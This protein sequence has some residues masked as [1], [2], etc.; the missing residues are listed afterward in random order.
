[1]KKIYLGI[2]SLVF[3]ASVFA[4]AEQAPY[5]KNDVVTS[6]A[7]FDLYTSF[8]PSYP[9]GPSTGMAA[10][11]YMFGNYYVSK[12][13]NDSIFRFDAT[14]AFVDVFVIPNLTGARAFT[15]DG[16]NIYISNNSGTIYRVDPATHT[17][18]PPH[19]TAATSF[20]VRGCSYSASLDGGAG[21]FWVCNFSTEIQSISMSGAVLSTIDAATHGLTGMYGIAVDEFTT[22]GPVIWAFAQMAPNASNITGIF[23]DGAPAYAA[24]DCFPDVSGTYSLVSS[25]AGGIFVSDAIVPGQTHIG[26]I[27]Q[28]S[29]EN[30]FVVYE[31]NN[32]SLGLDDV[33]N[34]SFEIYP[35]PAVGE[36][37]ISVGVSA[38]YQIVDLAGKVVLTG[39]VSE[40]TNSID[41]SQLEKGA[42]LVNLVQNGSKTSKKLTIQ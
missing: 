12:W 35:N 27:L 18:N 33:E 40:G 24:H 7:S 13:Q 31:L 22:G 38:E 17:L 30:V 36:V 28:G 21:G 26:G 9:G 5:I 10:A 39:S 23:T 15:S 4:Q 41:V 29:P 14:G 11:N 25:L 20:G 37:N 34:V 19:I 32:P 42:Y 3:S 1:M 6:K 2:L 8:V 16:T